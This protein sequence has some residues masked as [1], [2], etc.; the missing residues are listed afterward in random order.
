[1]HT[2]LMVLAMSLL[3]AMSWAQLPPGTVPEPNVL[4]LIAMG[5]VGI[6]LMHKRKK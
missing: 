4:M 2:K 1:M 3:P 5:V 6:A